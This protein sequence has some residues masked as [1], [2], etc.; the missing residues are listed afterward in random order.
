MFP[1]PHVSTL[2]ICFIAGLRQKSYSA[3]GKVTHRPRK[4]PLDFG[5][6]PDGV[7]SFGRQIN[8]VTDEYL[9]G[10]Q[11]T[12]RHILVNWATALEEFFKMHM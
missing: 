1:A 4:N 8:W 7:R 3:D 12:G 5:G 2:F 10:R 11:P 6:N 9:T